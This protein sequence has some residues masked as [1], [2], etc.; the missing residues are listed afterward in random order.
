M[1]QKQKMKE[2]FNIVFFGTPEFAIPSL[3]KLI[4]E[5]FKV[6]GIVTQPD[7]AKGRNL[8]LSSSPVKVLAEK[9]NIIIIQPENI[10][11]IKFIKELKSLKPDIFVI[12]A[13]GKILPKEIIYLPTFDSVNIHASLLPKYRGA[14]PIQSVILNGEKETGVTIMKMDENMDTGPILSQE[15]IQISPSVEFNKL[16]DK[17][18]DLGAELLNKTLISYFAHDLKLIKQNDKG[19]SYTKIIKKEDGYINWHDSAVQLERKIRAF[20][21]WPGTFTH[22]NN[23]KLK[24]IEVNKT[25]K[26]NT[27]APGT[28]FFDN[29]EIYIACQD[30]CLL[31]KKLQFESGKELKNDQFIAGH[32]NLD[33]E[34]L[35]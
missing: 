18:A 16:H 6:V 15:K 20:N 1:D 19:A 8:K 28:M 21:P 35:N 11:D 32:K 27:F 30:K 23:K 33:N 4:E 7:R 31:I 13:Y 9:N 3:E 25:D 14:S 17:L 2:K 29:G 12:I 5:G 10:N 34:I 26:K 24:I 22:L